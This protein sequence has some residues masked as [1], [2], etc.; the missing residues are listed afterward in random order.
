MVGN[1]YKKKLWKTDLFTVLTIVNTKAVDTS[2]GNM[3]CNAITDNKNVPGFVGLD[4][5]L[6]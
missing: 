2:V 4:W 6:P 1:K 5:S 3:I